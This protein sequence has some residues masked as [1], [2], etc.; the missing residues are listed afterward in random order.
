MATVHRLLEERGKRGALEAG[1]DRSVVEAAASYM[2]DEDTGLAE[3]PVL[4]ASQ[5]MAVMALGVYERG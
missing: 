2:G 1:I 3:F 5:E 4:T